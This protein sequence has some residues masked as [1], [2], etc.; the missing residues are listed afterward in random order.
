MIE[1]PDGYPIGIDRLVQ[2]CGVQC[3]VHSI[4]LGQ[5]AANRR[6]E[7]SAEPLQTLDGRFQPNLRQLS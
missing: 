1:S 4:V 2:D 5:N 6:R 7:A 3:L